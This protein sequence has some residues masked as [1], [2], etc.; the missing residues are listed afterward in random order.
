VERIS[1]LAIATLREMGYT[2]AA[3]LDGGSWK[4]QGLP[5]VSDCEMPL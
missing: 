1:T 3:A 2:R 4:E 5:L